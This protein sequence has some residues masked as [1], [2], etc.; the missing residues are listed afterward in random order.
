M[1]ELKHRGHQNQGRTQ[2]VFSL[3]LLVEVRDNPICT[4]PFECDPA[5]SYGF[6]GLHSYSAL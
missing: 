1:Y 5:G 3:S 4:S 6:A 2:P